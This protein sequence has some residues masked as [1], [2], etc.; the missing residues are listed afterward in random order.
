MR[1]PSPCP[2]EVCRRGTKPEARTKG[3]KRVPKESFS[4]LCQC[5]RT[6]MSL[7]SQREASAGMGPLAFWEGN[8]PHS[9][10]EAT[11][12]GSHSIK[13]L[14]R[15]CSLL[16]REHISLTQQARK[17]TLNQISAQWLAKHNLFST[18]SFD[19]TNFN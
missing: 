13:Q 3:N 17:L 7:S 8:N 6:E 1:E 11:A 10:K 16:I 18:H 14:F 2:A 9:G 12:S 4:L 5:A 15:I 19:L